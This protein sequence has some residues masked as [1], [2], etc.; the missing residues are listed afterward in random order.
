MN[1]YRI[2]VSRHVEN[3]RIP[4]VLV[5]ESAEEMSTTE[6]FTRFKMAV[7]MWLANNP[8]GQKANKRAC[9]R[10]NF[11]DLNVEL[12]DKKGNG[13]L[14]DLLT[15]NSITAVRIEMLEAEDVGAS[16]DDVLGED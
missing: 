1:V 13:P 4:A 7:K 9:G 10:F 16:W 8:G 5:L 15:H 11:G 14:F 3:D 12:S 2:D 6:A